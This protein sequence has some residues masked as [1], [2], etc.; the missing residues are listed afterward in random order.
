M[1]KIPQ[2]IGC[3]EAR[4]E[5]VIFTKD[6]TAI[7]YDTDV[8]SA[9]GCSIHLWM[10]ENGHDKSLMLEAVRIAHRHRDIVRVTY[11]VG[12]PTGYWSS[13]TMSADG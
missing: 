6:N 10:G 12:N 1:S 2:K 8:Y 9:E 5:G 11:S 13:Y 3:P 7:P 4:A